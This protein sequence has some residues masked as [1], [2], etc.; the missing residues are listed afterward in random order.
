MLQAA[1]PARKLRLETLTS[2]IVL[3]LSTALDGMFSVVHILQRR[4]KAA[5]FE[6]LVRYCAW[7]DPLLPVSSKHSLHIR[8]KDSLAMGSPYRQEKHLKPKHSLAIPRKLSERRR[9][10][11]LTENQDLSKKAQKKQQRVRSFLHEMDQML[12]EHE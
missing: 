12:S 7:N 5:G 9:N 11:I 8:Q 6:L 1:E 3:K 10:E 4:Q 2:T